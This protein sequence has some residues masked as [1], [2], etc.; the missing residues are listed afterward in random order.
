M[1]L[2]LIIFEPTHF[3]SRFLLC[4]EVAEDGSTRHTNRLAIHIVS[5]QVSI[6]NSSNS[7]SKRD[8][9]SSDRVYLR[10]GRFDPHPCAVV[11]TCKPFVRLVRRRSRTEASFFSIRIYSNWTLP[12]A[13]QTHLGSIHLAIGH[14]FFFQQMKLMHPNHFHR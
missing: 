8:Q 1:N 3:G 9:S 4:T 13:L 7:S 11:C 10:A 6:S 14:I 12:S 2:V 5:S